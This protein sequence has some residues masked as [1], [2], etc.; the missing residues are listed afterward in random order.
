MNDSTTS[1]RRQRFS[2]GQIAAVGV[3]V[4]AAVGFGVYK[5]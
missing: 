2:R 1:S 4:L 3:V 5:L